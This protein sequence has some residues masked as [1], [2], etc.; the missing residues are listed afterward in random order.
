MLRVSARVYRLP[1]PGEWVGQY[2]VVGPLGQGGQGHVFLAECSGRSC[3]LKFFREH[4]DN[5]WGELEMDI[6]RHV[7]H[8]NVVRVLGHG[9]WPYPDEGY[10][11]LVMEYVE[12][13][14]LLRHALEHNPSARKAATLMREAAQALGVVHRQGVLHRDIKPDNLL[15]RGADGRPVWV[16]FG[17][18]HLEGRPTLPRLWRLPPGTPEYTS[19]EAYRFL[20]EHPEDTARYRPGVADE[21]WALGVTLYELLTDRLPFGSRMGNPH[22]VKD[23]RTRTPVAPHEDNPRVPEALGRVCLRLLEKEPQARLADM[24]AVAAALEAAL[25]GAG[26]DWDV[27]L[28]DPYAPEVRTTEEIPGQVGERDSHERF[29]RHVV[30]A[31]PRR[32]R[33]RKVRRQP[34]QQEVPAAAL[35]PAQQEAP[36]EP[37][38]PRAPVDEVEGAAA[39]VVLP[40]STPAGRAPPGPR[41]RA[42]PLALLVGVLVLAG[43]WALRFRPES[44]AERPPASAPLAAPLPP[45]VGAGSPTPHPG[46][47]REVAAPDASSEAG[48]GAVASADSSPAPTPAPMPRDNDTRPKPAARPQRKDPRCVPTRQET[49]V[50][51]L[52]T[53]LLSGCTSTPQVVRPPPQPA[54][55]PPGAVKTMEEL[56]IRISQTASAQFPVDGSAQRVTVRESTPMRVFTTETNFGPLA[57]SELTGRLYLG[58][59]RVYGRFTQ[60]RTRTGETYPV[61]LELIGGYTRWGEPPGVERKDVGGPA[62]DAVVFST[63]YV[64]AVERFE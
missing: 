8:P 58:P 35:V 43:T 19:P 13:L 31:M 48:G 54:D 10:L 59:E 63:Q 28:M 55:C 49:C 38:A 44:G 34:A 52:C 2:R 37:P 9:R 23:L 7:Q 42:L 15:V 29:L 5:P 53:V 11:Y 45:G 1:E 17:V 3:V 14:P 36:R 64:R 25:A 62:D 57:G 60:A 32:G 24:E 22:M 61:C 4:P 6:L 56:G 51:G 30:A 27:P 33:V 46:L 47:V 21:V 26:E 18:G 39:L 12:G 16:D 41:A 50:V 40:P 20:A